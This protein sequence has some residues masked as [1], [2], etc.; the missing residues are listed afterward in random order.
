MLTPAILLLATAVVAQHEN[1]T[2]L[3]P[4]RNQAVPTDAFTVKWTYDF[5]YS[6]L[7]IL[8]LSPHTKS[9]W[10]GY[11]VST[12]VFAEESSTS[13]PAGVLSSVS[14]HSTS[15]LD[16]ILYSMD[17]TSMAGPQ[18]FNVSLLGTP[19][20]VTATSTVTSE[21]QEGD[22]DDGRGGLS[23]GAKAGIGVGA[24]VGALLVVT[25]IFV[26]FWWRWKSKK[27][28]TIREISAVGPA[29]ALFWGGQG[30]GQ[31]KM[32]PDNVPGPVTL[33]S[34]GGTSARRFELS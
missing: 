29:S 12:T 8:L 33:L 14:A 11:V 30:H 4:T 15:L 21:V 17:G 26:L 3:I 6:G 22:P 1:A 16:L 20:T 34:E 24:G 19:A 13:L 9:Y 18:V 27:P 2:L 28:K 10:T 7:F 5:D 25:G 31:E 32:G 23:T